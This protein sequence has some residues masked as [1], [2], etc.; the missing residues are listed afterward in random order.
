RLRLLP[1]PPH[2]DA[3][4]FSYQ[5]R[6]SPEKGLSPFWSHLLAGARIPVFTGNSGF[7]L[8]E[9]VRN[10]FRRND[11]E[12]RFPIFYQITMNKFIFG[13]L[14]IGLLGFIWRLPVCCRQGIGLLEFRL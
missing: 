7:L 6:A 14:E 10:R 5:E 1:T 4:T 9:P 8:P 12:W 2:G 3:V 13:Y 11:Q